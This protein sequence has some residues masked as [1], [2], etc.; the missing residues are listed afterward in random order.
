MRKAMLLLAVL[1]LVGLVWAAETAQTTIINFRC[2]VC[3]KDFST[4][5]ELTSHIAT[6]HPGG[7]V[8]AADPFTGTWK[9][10]QAKTKS[11]P[12]PTPKDEAITLQA[13]NNG[14]KGTIDDIGPDG[15]PYHVEWSGLYG[16]DNPPIG[17][18]SA[19]ALSL[20]RVDANTLEC[21]FKK[22]GKELSKWRISVSKNGKTMT[23]TGNGH[24]VVYE[25]Q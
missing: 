4:F 23:A 3:G 24:L 6:A 8:P 10:N 19:D 5:D 11:Y 18:P 7:V 2:P 14:L 17:D 15:K 21:V 25:R 1:G 20:K 12:G 16:R 13:L 22:D 9:M